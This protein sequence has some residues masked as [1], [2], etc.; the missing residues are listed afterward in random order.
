M[1]FQLFRLLIMIA[2]YVTAQDDPHLVDVNVDYS[3]RT[4]KPGNVSKFSSHI[5]HDQVAQF[6]QTKR[7]KVISLSKKL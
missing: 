3:L 2:S 5:L 6:V 4:L 1:T 7:K